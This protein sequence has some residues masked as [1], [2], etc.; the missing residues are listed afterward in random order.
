MTSAP[1]RAPAR[2]RLHVGN[3][4]ATG[5]MMAWAAGFPAAEALL[6]DWDPAPLVA[7]RFVMALAVLLPLW[8]LIEGPARLRGARW[9]RGMA[10]GGIGFGGGAWA[11][12]LS[13]A[14]TDP[15]TVAI[16]AAATPLCAT[17]ID[18]IWLRRGFSRGFLVGLIAAVIGGVVAT[19]GSVPG[20]LGLGALFAILSGLLFSWGSLMTLRDLADH[21]VLGRTAVTA[22]GATVAMLAASLGMAAFGHADLPAS[23]W[24]ARTLI[25]LAAYGII[26]FALSQFLWV[27]AAERLGVAVASFHINLTPFYTMLILLAL[28]DGWSWP[29][30]IGAAIVGLGMVLAQR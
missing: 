26:A 13:Q 30:A 20:S 29:Q 27:A 7:A 12:I 24:T 14:Y 23:I 11:I 16:F 6:R 5:S 19:G 22:V 25:P 3:L 18:W 4:A 2:Q 8:L 17:V 15:V 1:A 10:V 28:G 21:S 9:G